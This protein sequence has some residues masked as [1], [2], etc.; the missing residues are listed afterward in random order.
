[1]S[2]EHRRAHAQRPDSSRRRRSVARPATIAG[3]ALV[4]CLTTLLLL[5]AAV[6]GA[7]WTRQ[8]SGTTNVLLDLDFVD[9]QHGWAVGVRTIVGT[10]DG[11]VHWNTQYS[12]PTT[13]LE[14]VDFV[15]TTT[16]WAVGSSGGNGIILRTTDGGATWSPQTCPTVKYGLYAVS[17]VTTSRGWATGY[18]G[19]ILTTSNGGATWAQIQKPFEPY[20]YNTTW[21]SA[22]FADADH[23]WIVGDSNVAWPGTPAWSVTK[24]GGSGTYLYGVDCASAT[25]AWAAGSKGGNAAIFATS[26]GT[27]WTQQSTGT[28]P[29]T[30][31]DVSAPTTTHVWA[32]LNT[33]K[34]YST[35][36]GGSTWQAQETGTSHLE[37]IC[38]PDTQHG[39]AIDRSQIYVYGGTPS[40][41]PV[42][43]ALANVTVKK[44]KTAKLPYRID[45]A[46]A[47]CTV[48]IKIT[49]NGRTVKTFTI[50]NVPP[51]KKMTKSFTCTFR[52]GTYTWSV[53]A[54][55]GGVKSAKASSKKLYVK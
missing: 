51:N 53:S 40:A 33:G 42:P 4:V 28:V 30:F 31:N 55:A 44:G 16:G 10:A 5:P 39:W 45:G 38:F 15:N 20:T 29:G 54:V 1:M 9:A 11:G 36:N 24:P 50:K 47:A 7:N 6:L 2:T 43:K 35:S 8:T 18:G 41:K 3:T 17:F 22:A 32:A 25:H 23:G 19:A 27:T 13:T 12:D 52:K 34:A 21:R 48:T 37:A 26:N 49:G 46:T 14:G